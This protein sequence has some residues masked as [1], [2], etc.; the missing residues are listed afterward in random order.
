M[1]IAS[2]DI[3]I[4]KVWGVKTPELINEII[5]TWKKH[6]AIPPEVDTQKRAGQ[7][8]LVVRN[9]SGEIVGITTAAQFFYQPLKNNLFALRGMLVPNFRVPGL[10]IKMITTTIETL[11]SFTKESSESNKPIGVIAEVEVPNIKSG[12]FTKLASGMTLLGFSSQDH[13]VYVYYFK[14]AVY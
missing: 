7:V 13:P 2:N 6:N 8:V 5:N 4:Q 10:F 12:R 9:G 1:S 3:V 11:E 14:G